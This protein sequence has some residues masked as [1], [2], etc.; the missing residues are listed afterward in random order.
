MEL[1]N[2]WAARLQINGIPSSIDSIRIYRT[3]Y[4]CLMSIQLPQRQGNV[5]MDVDYR[6]WIR[7]KYARGLD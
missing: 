2:N 3:V 5:L 7:I 6:M 4:L 1:I